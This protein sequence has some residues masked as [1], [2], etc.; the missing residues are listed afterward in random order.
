MDRSRARIRALGFFQEAELEEKPGSAP[1]R[2]EVDVTVQE[3]STGSFSLGVGFSSTDNFIVD[4]SI[5]E[6]NLMGRGQ[7]L[8]LRGPASSRTRLVDLYFQQPYFLNR[9]LVLG[10]EA[11]NQRSDFREADFIR[12]RTGFG[13]TTGFNI[14]EYGSGGV[15]YQLASDKVTIDTNSTISIPAGD[16][17]ASILV[18]GATPISV[19]SPF[20]NANGDQVVQV[21]ANICDFLIQALTPTCAS[22]GRFLTSRVGFTATFDTR[23]D[24]IKPRRGWRAGTSLQ[25]AGLGGDVNYYRAEVTASVYHPLFGDFIG[26]LK[27]NAG[28]IQGYAG[29]DV[30]LSDRFFIGGGNFRGFEPAGVGPRF[31]TSFSQKGDPTGQ[32][33]G[34]KFYAVGSVEILLPLPLPEEYGIRAALFSDFGT[35]GLVDDSVKAINAVPAFAFEVPLRDAAGNIVVDQNGNAIIESVLAPIQDDLALRISAGVTVSW[36]SPFGP[37]RFDIARVVK[38]EFYD[39]TEGFRFSAGTVF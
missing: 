1:D 20:A 21:L 4:V 17:P 25:L 31:L 18:P 9:N 5:E 23:D 27:G 38:K 15:S 28:Y 37:I 13:V 30:R 19:S 36:D 26:A 39:Q 32:S 14:S 11:F 6:R 8:R 22:Q 2:T 24:P 12:N 3:Q 33:I 35:V 16:D 34:A 10:L 29:D 7:L